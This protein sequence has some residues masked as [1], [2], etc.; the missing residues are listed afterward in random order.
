M[1]E[2]SL[3]KRVIANEQCIAV[4]RNRDS[5]FICTWIAHQGYLHSMELLT[6]LEASPAAI[7]QNLTALSNVGF[8]AYQQRPNDIFDAW[9]VTKEGYQVLESLGFVDPELRRNKVAPWLLKNVEDALKAHA[10]FGK[11]APSIKYVRSLLEKVRPDRQERLAFAVCWEPIEGD[12]CGTLLAPSGAGLSMLRKGTLRAA[13][14]VGEL[15]RADSIDQRVGTPDWKALMDHITGPAE[16]VVPDRE[17]LPVR[18]QPM[19]DQSWQFGHVVPAI[20]GIIAAGG[21]FAGAVAAAGLSQSWVVGILLAT[22]LAAILFVAAFFSSRIHKQNRRIQESLEEINELK[23]QLVGKAIAN[24]L[25]VTVSDVDRDDTDWHKV[26]EALHDFSAIE[27]AVQ[28]EIAG[29]NLAVID[30]HQL[31]DMLLGVALTHIQK[32]FERLCPEVV[33]SIKILRRKAEEEY[34]ECLYGQAW[35][36]QYHDFVNS[37][38]VLNNTNNYAG[39]ALEQGH[40]VFS[41]N[42]WKRTETGDEFHYPYDKEVGKK[43]QELGVQGVIVAPISLKNADSGRFEARAV[44]KIDYFVVDGLVDNHPTRRTIEFITSRLGSLLQQSLMLS[45]STIDDLTLARTAE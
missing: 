5:M 12:D 14:D 23:K 41:G 38:K 8:V 35:P 31:T 17:H 39:R 42:L 13:R 21:A 26:H 30:C 27:R 9:V 29:C 19:K 37:F 40:K 43:L 28:D 45:G 10:R 32:A 16:S 44:F 2:L 34:F 3:V 22:A 20:A 15:A 11:R 36:P 18:R 7:V 4:S 24:P 6:D 1:S 33:C 25:T